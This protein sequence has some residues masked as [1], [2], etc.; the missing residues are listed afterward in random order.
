MKPVSVAILIVLVLTFHLSYSYALTPEEVLQLKKAGVSD[1]TIQMMLKQEEDARAQDASNRFGTHEVRDRD[2]KVKTVYSTG[3]SSVD[4]EEK[5]KV[6]KAW[7]MLD[8]MIIDGREDL[9][10]R[11]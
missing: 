8:N 6:E 4:Q 9:R 7:K 5:E 3:G 11:H 2:G 10:K 1:R